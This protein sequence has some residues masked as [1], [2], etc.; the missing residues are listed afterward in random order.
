MKRLAGTSKRTR[1][2]SSQTSRPQVLRT[3]R[4][5]SSNDELRRRERLDAGPVAR[6]EARRRARRSARDAAFVERLRLGSAPPA[7]Q[8]VE[9]RE[10]FDGL[11]RFEDLGLRL[12]TVGSEPDQDAEFVLELAATVAGGAEERHG[13]DEGIDVER[14]HVVVP[15]GEVGREVELHAEVPQHLLGV[16]TRTMCPARGDRRSRNEGS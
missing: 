13:G 1:N 12:A 5:R 11:L 3:M 2:C 9:A 14:E 10:R 6:V 15:R 4:R 8:R 7:D 16:R